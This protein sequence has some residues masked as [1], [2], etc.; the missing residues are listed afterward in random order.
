MALK[1]L[2]LGG[3]GTFGG[4]LAQLLKDEPRLTLII[5]GRSIE[6]ARAFCESLYGGAYAIPAVFERN[7]DVETQ[8]RALAPHIV[9]DASGPFQNYS[10]SYSMVRAAI[11][12]GIDYLDLADGAEFVRG[13]AQFDVAAKARGVFVL[14]GVSS[15]PVLTAAVARSLSTGMARIDSITGGIAPSPYAGV[16]LN[17]IRAIASYGGKPVQ[18]RRDGGTAD[19]PALIDSRR[20][21]IAPPGQLPL[22]RLR[23]SLVDV[24]DLTLLP[25][26]WPEVKS[27]WIGVAPVPA[28]LHRALSAFAAL[29]RWK[30]LPSLSPFAPLMHRTINILRWGEH[31]GGMFVDVEGRDGNGAAPRRSWHLLAEGD[32]GPLIPSMAAEAVV[33]RCLDSKRP[34]PGARA[35]TREIEVG[36][37]EALFA[38]RKI[39]TGVWQVVPN[40]PD[41]PVHRRVLGEAWMELPEP[42]RAMHDLRGTLVAEGRASVERGSGL[43]ARLV[44]AIFRFPPATSDVLVRV[45]F[46]PVNGRE[47]W[48]REFGGYRFSST[49]EQG[50]GAFEHLLCERFGPFSFGLALVTENG[51]LRL[52]ARGWRFLGIPLPTALVPNGETYEHADDGRFNFHVEI[53]Q[54]FIGLIVRYQ[55]WLEPTG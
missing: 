49:Q 26:L 19:A 53:R 32:D 34:G 48:Q 9:V 33:R 18:L 16:G 51:R 36:D 8:L 40:D 54:R 15:F 52:I 6:K 50:R 11:A 27:V 25:D 13:V 21:T 30:L 22:R 3:Y 24:P 17:V 41:Q 46:R 23:F 42:I 20:Y 44:A 35:A 29:V 37:Y 4:R 1:V 55:G 12:L 38:R 31:R 45:T 14:S 5:A 39:L 47:I 10:D 2:I 43:L 28:I 7:G